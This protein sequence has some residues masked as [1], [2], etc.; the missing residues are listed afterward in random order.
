[1]DFI[2]IVLIWGLIVSISFLLVV[3]IVLSVI[4]HNNEEKQFPMKKE[5]VRINPYDFNP[6][7][8][9]TL[10]KRNEIDLDQ[11]PTCPAK[12]YLIKKLGEKK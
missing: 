3:F 2:T 7:D 12:T 11:I 10:V 8:L 5:I 9:L 1:M 6:E 4:N